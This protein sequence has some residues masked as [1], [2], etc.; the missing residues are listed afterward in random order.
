[1]T[2]YVM[3]YDTFANFEVVIPMYLLKTATEIKTVGMTMTPVKSS[4]GLTVT[5]DMTV[6][7]VVLKEED[8]FIIP[9]GDPTVLD[10]EEVFYQ[11]IRQG[12]EANTL[13][14]AICAAPTHLAKA[15]VLANREYTTSMPH[16][17]DS[18]FDPDLFVRQNVVVDEHIVTA[19]PSGYAEFGIVL[20]Q[21]MDIYQDE[22]DF[23][24]TVRFF[25]DYEIQG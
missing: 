19:Q 21:L 2:T 25:M 16:G 9:G 15:G 7:D 23:E 5:P 14:A 3:I 22:E 8:V 24:E 18:P 4:E 20:G 10:G 11:L 13:L 6:E 12:D 17:I 1:M